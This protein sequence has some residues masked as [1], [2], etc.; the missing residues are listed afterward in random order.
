MSD[1]RA[2]PDLDYE[3]FRDLARE[4]FELGSKVMPFFPFDTPFDTHFYF[5]GEDDL[6]TEKVNRA[7]PVFIERL[8]R[9]GIKV[10]HG[11]L[12]VVSVVR[13]DRAYE[14]EIS[15]HAVWTLDRVREIPTGHP[16]IQEIRGWV[17]N[18]EEVSKGVR[19]WFA[20][21]R[22][23]AMRD[24]RAPLLVFVFGYS[25]FSND[26]KMGGVCPI[27]PYMQNL[28]RLPNESLH[29][30]T[31]TFAYEC[32]ETLRQIAALAYLEGEKK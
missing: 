4:A 12:A 28:L 15:A 29:D 25:G 1:E 20:I 26:H 2:A 27:S 18:W 13:K 30:V 23:Q 14:K 24:L 11:D 3:T 19:Q 32:C 17:D 10:P 22:Y 8:Q 6:F 31:L 5:V 9:D 21:A 7:I 16:L